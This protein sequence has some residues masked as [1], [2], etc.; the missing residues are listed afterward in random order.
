[1]ETGGGRAGG[2]PW[3]AIRAENPQTR[4]L[5]KFLRTRVDESGKTLAN[6]ATEINF[7]K[8]QIS[9]YLG[10]KIPSRGFVTALIK[11]TV[12]SAIRERRLHEA[13]TL[14]DAALHPPRAAGSVSHPTADVTDLVQAQARQIETYDRL[15]RSLEQQAELRQ[16]AENSAKLIM[17]LLTMID[18]LQN[19]V[20]G[21]IKE[22]DQ[23]RRSG[24]LH[25]A[26]EDTQRKLSRAQAQKGKAEAQHRRAK[27]KQQQA[28][29]L[30][31]RL[32]AQIDAL[33][34][35]LG[36]L[37]G[38]DP[39]PH[40][41][42]S[43]HLPAAQQQVPDRFS[44]DPEGDDIE[45]ALARV[46]AVNDTDAETV[47]R[48]TAELADGDAAEAVVV[49][50]NSVTSADPP[51]NVFSFLVA[52][53]RDSLRAEQSGGGALVQ[54]RLFHVLT[55]ASAQILGPDHPDTLAAARLSDWSDAEATRAW[56][57]RMEKALSRTRACQYAPGHPDTTTDASPLSLIEQTRRALSESMSTLAAM[58]ETWQALAIARLIGRRLA[59]SGPQHLRDGGQSLAE[60]A[61]RGC[62]SFNPF[63][64]ISPQG[65]D[66]ATAGFL[67]V[68]DAQHLRQTLMSLGAL[69]G[70]AGISL[71]GLACA[72]DDEEA[73]W[74]CI[75]GIDAADEAGDRIRAVLRHM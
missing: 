44:D 28:E 61:D 71:V 27:E 2:R 11:A 3:G 43:D 51:D 34:D 60:V 75:T 54:D 49:P 62:H 41:R 48:I 9:V 42:L 64:G 6:L 32:Q 20:T 22:R 69:L 5:A 72:T 37:R 45:A 10:G 35:E 16:T 47:D 4:Q 17:V 73:Y 23:L 24:G 30:A 68:T 14:L 31:A 50:N 33:T 58:A 12:P 7:S 18:N 40:D 55:E 15:T 63:D 65:P 56:L 36:R 1:M 66:S 46:E 25:G 52:L 39:S 19:R 38:D 74:N 59:A 13:T 53:W 57:A 8:T 70:E 29:S 67:W 21:L 26:L